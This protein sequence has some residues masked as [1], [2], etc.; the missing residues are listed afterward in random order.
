MFTIIMAIGK[1]FTE[2]QQAVYYLEDSISVYVKARLANKVIIA[3]LKYS[4]LVNKQ[5]IQKILWGYED[6]IY[7]Y[8]A[9]GVFANF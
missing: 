2:K 9:C 8:L 5:S 7:Y 3:R 1:T 4:G 6:L